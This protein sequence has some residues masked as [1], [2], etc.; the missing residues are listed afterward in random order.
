M[1]V[2][3]SSS[4]CFRTA[5]VR[6]IWPA[7]SFTGALSSMARVTRLPKT[8]PMMKGRADMGSLAG[9]DREQDGAADHPGPGR[10]LGAS[11]GWRGGDDAGGRGNVQG[12]LGLLDRRRRGDEFTVD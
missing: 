11:A 8:A 2:A 7:S 3:W 4:S 5:S 1:N 9:D 12:D 10:D 6:M